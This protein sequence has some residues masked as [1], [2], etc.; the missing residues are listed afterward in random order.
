MARVRALVVDDERLARRRLLRL[1]KEEPGI[2]VVGECADGEAAVLAIEEKAPD[3]VFLDVQMP[4]FNGFEV[5]EAIGPERAPAVVFVTAYDQYAL[6][7]FDVHALDYLLKPFPRPRF[8]QAVARARTEVMR[9]RAGETEDSGRRL[10]SLLQELRGEGKRLE[11]LAVNTGG[12]VFF[13]RMEEVDWIESEGNYLRLHV[14]AELHLVRGT[15]KGLEARLD[16]ERFVRIHRSTIV[17]LDRIR[18]VQP[19]F[20]GEH[21]L[22][23]RD[24]TRLTTGGE[25]GKRLRGLLRN[26]L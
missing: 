21:I 11:R 8:Q 20:Q 15:L 26:P 9:G 23:L 12:R 17:N 24:G 3:L 5:L 25:Y 22:I 6:R 7:A 4:A 10:L 1:L 14:G 16:P 19:W 18:E 2:D 13:L